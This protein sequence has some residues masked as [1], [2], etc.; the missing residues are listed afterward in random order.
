[1]ETEI[2]IDTGIDIEKQMASQGNKQY[3]C[4]ERGFDL[5]F[6]KL[7]CFFFQVGSKLSVVQ[8][9]KLYFSGENNVQIQI[10]WQKGEIFPQ[11]REPR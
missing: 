3:T 2:G 5:G 9:P 8:A 1:M 11:W 10:Q 4:T 7:M 6:N